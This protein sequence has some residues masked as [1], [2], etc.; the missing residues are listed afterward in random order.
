MNLLHKTRRHTNCLYGTSSQLPYTRTKIYSPLFD[1]PLEGV[2]ACEALVAL[3][4][5]SGTGGTREQRPSHVSSSRA[6]AWHSLNASARNLGLSLH[7]S[8]HTHRKS[9]SRSARSTVSYGP[10][11]RRDA[12][13]THTRCAPSKSA[14]SAATSSGGGASSSSSDVDARDVEAAP[15]RTRTRG[16]ASYRV[17]ISSLKTRRGTLRSTGSCDA[18]RRRST[19][20]VDATDRLASAR[21]DADPADASSSSSGAGAAKSPCERRRRGRAR[22]GEKK[23][24][25]GGEWWGWRGDGMTRRVSHL[26]VLADEAD[27]V[28]LDGQIRR[29]HRRGRRGARVAVCRSSLVVTKPRR[30]ATASLPVTS[31]SRAGL[32][33]TRSAPR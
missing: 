29:R 15:V 30:V 1:P 17:N 28:L 14:K 2:D 8:P 13:V 21:S 3:D 18:L 20:R 5:G 25:G 31:R 10:A 12:R 24:R 16:L 6:N 33:L 9:R 22:G 7:V 27:G 4:A 11:V 32:I 23:V 26:D 19:R